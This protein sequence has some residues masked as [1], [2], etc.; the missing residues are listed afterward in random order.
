[1]KNIVPLFARWTPKIHKYFAPVFSWCTEKI[2]EKDCPLFARWKAKIHKNIAP[3]FLWCT[4]KINEKYCP[5]ICT[6]DYKN[7]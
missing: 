1:M 3:L 4:E 6:V 7:T 2:I 5:F